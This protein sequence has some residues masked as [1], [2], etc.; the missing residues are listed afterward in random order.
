MIV[1]IE[2]KTGQSR[3]CKQAQGSIGAGCIE[4]CHCIRDFFKYFLYNKLEKDIQVCLLL[5]CNYY[6]LLEGILGAYWWEY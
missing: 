1:G 4:K 5:S 6:G 2:L 3:H